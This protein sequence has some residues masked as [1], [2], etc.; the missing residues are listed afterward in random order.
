MR[1]SASWSGG[2][3]RQLILLAGLLLFP[4]ALA[5]APVEQASPTPVPQQIAPTEQPSATTNQQ[6]VFPNEQPSP[7][8]E[9][10]N[11]KLQDQCPDSP[12]LEEVRNTGT[13]R[14]VVTLDVDFDPQILADP[15]KAAEQRRKIAE[16]QE[17]LIAELEKTEAEVLRRYNNLPQLALRVEEPAL[18]HLLTSPLVQGIQVDVPDPPASG[19]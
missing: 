2:Q 11:P 4:V 10:D 17:Q 16:S 14:L 6:Q 7:M 18:C 1:T 13:L 9:P 15:E 12:L 19:G 3:L 8:A 5:C